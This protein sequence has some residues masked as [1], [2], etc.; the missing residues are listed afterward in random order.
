MIERVRARLLKDTGGVATFALVVLSLLYFFD[1]F[2]TAAFG[3][4]APDIQRSFHLSDQD[5][6]GLVILNVSLLLLLAIPVG[7]LADRVSRTRL[8]VLSGVIAGVFSLGTGLAGSIVLLTFMRFGNG[9]GLLANGPVHNSLLSDYY[10]VNNRATVFGDHLNAM[11]L[12]AI[13]GPAFAGILG[14]LFGWRAPFLVLMIPILITTYYVRRLHEPLRGGTDDPTAAIN[15]AEQ[16]PVRFRE[17]V[18]ALWGIRTLRRQFIGSL[19]AGAGL[20]PLA[21]YLPLYLDRVYHLG[22]LPRG[23]IGAANAAVTF[24]GIQRS[25]QWT[26]GWFA[27]G[28]GEP[29]RRSAYCLMAV[30]VAI[31]ALAASPFLV[32]SI[33]IGLGLSFVIGIFQPPFYAV[34]ALVSPARSRTLSFSFGALFLVIGVVFLFYGT[35][36]GAISDDHGIRWGIAVLGPYWIIGG[37]ILTTAAKFVADDASAALRSMAVSAELHQRSE[38][39][40]GALLVVRHLDVAY[41][42]T[43]VLFGIDLEVNEGEIVALL[44]T[45]GAG[46]STVL[47]AISGLLPMMSGRIVFDGEEITRPDPNAIAKRGITQVPG[48]R[49]VFPGLT[50]AEN[51]R[52]AAWLFRK[53]KEYVREATD[54]VLEYFPT[55]ANRLDTPAGSLSGGEQQML[56]LAKAF[57]AKPKLLMIDELSLGLAPTIVES[58]LKIVRAIHANGTTILLVEQSVNTA[59]RLADRAVFL[60]KGEVRFQGSTTELLERTDLLRAVYLK[61]AAAGNGAAKTKANGAAKATRRRK[62]L[63]AP[64]AAVSVGPVVLE[65]IGLAKRYGGVRAVDSVSL[66]LHEGEVLGLIGPNG[67]GKTTLFDMLSGFIPADEGRVLLGGV[68]ASTWPAYARARGGIGRTFQDARLW[69]SLTVREV[70]AASM[71]GQVE[72]GDPLS[73][74]F[75]TPR[76]VE[77]EGRLDIRVSEV[78]DLLGLGAFRDKFVSELSTGSRRMVELGCLLANKATV[79]LLDEPSSGIAQKEAEALGPVL[80]AVQR[81]LGASILIIEHDM[82]L[83]T[84]IA[85]RLVALEAGAV[86]ATGSPDDVLRHPRV[87][88]AYLGGDELVEK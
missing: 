52:A 10:P 62:A 35:G 44:G 49:G 45:N 21:F 60:E 68:D 32:L 12:G 22:P 9:V 20:L 57:I 74:L 11:Y 87:V 76:H 80:K 18:R 2:D 50:V 84:S 71:E 75:G 81:H 55:L 46:K 85:D 13:A 15:M 67:A 40:T 64:V 59:L 65:A 16:A 1:E 3:V 25:G 86:V 17:G 7:H 39:G 33:A 6:G 78:I 47:K 26:P 69:P 48:G 72:L 27:K 82:P 83:L 61:G 8:V 23:V 38:D 31:S 70:I 24:I 54:R 36:M 30:G 28:M 66:E 56:S 19:F 51:L 53:D 29:L 34:Q 41:D 88:A 42:Q 5:F 37:I 79:L 73:A 77:A 58:L 4:L 43:Q 14:T 63:V